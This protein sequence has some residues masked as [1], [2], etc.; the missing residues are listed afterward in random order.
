[1]VHKEEITAVVMAVVARELGRADVEID[2]RP[3]SNHGIDSVK[4][5]RVVSALE[6]RYGIEFAD[7]DILSAKSL[8]QIVDVVV[9]KVS[10]SVEPAE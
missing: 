3:I 2:N 9:G 10:A 8:I 5:M 4:M 7:H 6:Q 1:M